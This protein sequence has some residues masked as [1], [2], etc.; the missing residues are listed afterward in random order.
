MN[1]VLSILMLFDW[2]KSYNLDVFS[3]PKQLPGWMH[4]SNQNNNLNQRKSSNV[5]HTYY[6]TKL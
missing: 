3:E 4:N 2:I 1:E 5:N 6:K